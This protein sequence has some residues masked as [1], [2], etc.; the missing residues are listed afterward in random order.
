MKLDERQLEYFRNPSFLKEYLLVLNS[1]FVYSNN[2]IEKDN[3]PIGE[4]Y[5][6]HKVNVLSDNFKAFRILLRKLNSDD[7]RLT[8]DL[9]KEVANTLNYHAPYI[10]NDY[11]LRDTHVK[12]ENKY[13]IESPDNIEKD[14][15]QL[16]D[17]YYGEWSNL[18]VFEREARFNIEFLR[19]HPFEDGNGRTSRLILNYNMLR[20]GYAPILIPEDIREE[21]FHARNIED[22][23]WIKNLFKTL[24]EKEY[25]AINDMI[26]NNNL[27]DKDDFN[28]KF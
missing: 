25:N 23:N 28:I 20:Q 14:M 8:Q 26:D 3:G 17:N 27:D 11:R 1:R 19:I 10:S 15:A 12:F 2:L 5:S 13:P 22:V 16:L 7:N 21:Y 24:C 4:L 9:I 18:D 6:D